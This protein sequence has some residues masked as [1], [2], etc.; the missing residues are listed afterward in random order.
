MVDSPYLSAVA[1]PLRW[2]LITAYWQHFSRLTIYLQN[3][4]KTVH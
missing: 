4:L 1:E 3:I 2:I